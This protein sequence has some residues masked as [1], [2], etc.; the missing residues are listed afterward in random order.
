MRARMGRA[1]MVDG[2]RRARGWTSVR[3]T[4]RVR[5]RACVLTGGGKEDERCSR[6]VARGEQS[7]GACDW[8]K[9]FI[10]WWRCGW[11]NPICSGLGATGARPGRRSRDGWTRGD[12]TRGVDRDARDED[13]VCARRVGGRR[14]CAETDRGR[15]RCIRSRRFASR[16]RVA[17]RNPS[18]VSSPLIPARV[19]M[20]CR[21]K[22]WAGTIRS[23]SSPTW[24]LRRSRI[25]LRRARSRRKPWVLCSRR[26]SSSLK[27]ETL[28]EFKLSAG[29]RRI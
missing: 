29:R 26:R 12:A 22:P 19:A 20:V 1:R 8:T 10:R 15:R 21:S 13:A 5:A 16:A 18:T 14:G 25:G 17:K 27:R 9:R 3:L 4:R 11:R 2:G 7:C 23:A 24:T 6:G 28:I